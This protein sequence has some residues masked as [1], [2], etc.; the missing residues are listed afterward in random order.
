MIFGVLVKKVLHHKTFLFFSLF[1][2]PDFLYL[3]D[4]VTLPEIFQIGY[5]KKKIKIKIGITKCIH[6]YCNFPIFRIVKIQ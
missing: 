1:V 3:L 4:Y 2:R 6:V 5:R